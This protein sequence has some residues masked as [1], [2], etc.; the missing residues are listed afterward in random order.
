MGA[1]VFATLA[2]VVLTGATGATFP[3]SLAFL[4]IAIAWRSHQGSPRDKES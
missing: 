3:I 2:V 1:A 4:A